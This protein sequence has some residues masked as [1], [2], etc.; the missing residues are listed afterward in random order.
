PPVED[1]QTTL[2]SDSLFDSIVGVEP[3]P[4]VHEPVV[5]LEDRLGTFKEVEGTIDEED[6]RYEASRCLNC[7]TYCYD[8][9][10]EVS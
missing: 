3:T 10:L 6:A 8:H 9:D 1:R 4:K 7:G 2:I 5:T